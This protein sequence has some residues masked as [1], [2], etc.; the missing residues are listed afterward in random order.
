MRL[1]LDFI[2]ALLVFALP[3]AILYLAHGAGF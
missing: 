1:L 2:G 3:I